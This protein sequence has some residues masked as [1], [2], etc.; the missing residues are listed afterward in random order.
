MQQ[1]EIK[2]FYVNLRNMETAGEPGLKPIPITARQLEALVRLAEGSAK[3]RLS[4][5]VT[6]LDAKRAINILKHCLMAVGFDYET[7]TFDIDR[8]STGIPA[9]QRSRIVIIR[10]IIDKFIEKGIKSI[11]LDEIT[12][13]AMNKGITRDQ[14]EEVID[15]LKHDGAIFEPRKNFLSKI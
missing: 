15:R 2:E 6:K 11:P 9:S 3:V 12:A 4:N 13:E 7:Q 5:Q 10:E 1:K 8:I 14:V